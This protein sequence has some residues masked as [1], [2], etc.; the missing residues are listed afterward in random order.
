MPRRICGTFF[1]FG[2]QMW[3]EA[4]ASAYIHELFDVFGHIGEHPYTGRLRRELGD[5][6]R[7]LP[8]RSHVV[9]FMDWQGE[10]AIVRVL[11]GSRDYV[12]SSKA[13]ILFTRSSRILKIDGLMLTA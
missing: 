7:S 5:D 13:T 2:E 9:F 11:H 4:K 1:V 10:T 6:L 3:G 8:H 12:A